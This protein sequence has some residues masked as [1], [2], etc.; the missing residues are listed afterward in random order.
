MLAEL[1]DHASVV[2]AASFGEALEHAGGCPRFD[3]VVLDPL[4]P[5][6]DPFAG[7]EAFHECAPEALLVILSTL[8]NSRDILRTIERGAMGYIPKSAGPEETLRG[9]RRV[10]AG[11]IWLPRGLLMAPQDGPFAERP[12]AATPERSRDRI[13]RLTQRQRGILGELAQGKTNVQ[14]ADGLGLSKHT[15]RLHV[16]AI[17][18]TLGVANRTQAARFATDQYALVKTDTHR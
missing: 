13:R 12:E 2:E 3:L 16:S 6:R 10:L 1:D 15:V 4:M 9:L 14:I 17:L 18:R 8:D 7:I 5:D 11:E